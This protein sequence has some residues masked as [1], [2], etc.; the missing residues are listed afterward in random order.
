LL[1][2]GGYDCEV[3]FWD[4]KDRKASY[5]IQKIKECKD[6][7]TSLAFDKHSLIVSS[8]DG[9]IRTF[10]IRMGCITEDSFN[11]GI[12]NCSLSHDNRLLTLSC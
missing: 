6:S 8:M 5:C 1:A 11:I 3:R 4:L 2:T 9:K 7:V 12:L 10:D